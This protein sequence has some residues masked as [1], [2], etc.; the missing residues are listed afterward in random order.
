[1]SFSRTLAFLI[2]SGIFFSSALPLMAEDAKVD[3]GPELSMVVP[4]SEN[5]TRSQRL[6]TTL[7]W[8]ADLDAAAEAA[9]RQGKLVFWLH[10][11][12]NIDGFT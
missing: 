9:T 12:G 7:P 3:P 1:M 6:A 11:L 10:L 4:G 2:V 5:K 8:Y